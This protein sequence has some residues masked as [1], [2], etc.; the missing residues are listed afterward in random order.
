[1]E[2]NNLKPRSLVL[3][4]TETQAIS[5]YK[6]AGDRLRDLSGAGAAL[7]FDD[8]GAGFSSLANLKDYAFDYLKIDKS[9]IAGL[10]DGGEG[11][12]IAKAIAGLA[13]DL[14]LTVIAEGVE[15]ARTAEAAKAIGCSLAQGFEFGAPASAP[16]AGEQAPT[17]RKGKRA[18]FG[19]S[20]R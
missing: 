12:R 4:V 17:V 15:D 5:E 13:A 1:M 20:L 8:F 7:A 18:L 19:S 16:E 11:A 10:A 6:G 14:G 9:F 3:E 2:D